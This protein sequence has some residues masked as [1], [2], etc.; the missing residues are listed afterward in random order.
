[1]KYRFG[2]QLA[3][4]ELLATMRQRKLLQGQIMDRNMAVVCFLLLVSIF[5]IFSSPTRSR[6]EVARLRS[7]IGR[8]GYHI[9][10]RVRRGMGYRKKCVPKLEQK[11]WKFRGRKICIMMKKIVCYALD[12]W[13]TT[14]I[15]LLTANTLEFLDNGPLLVGNLSTRKIKTE[16]RCS[17]L[18]TD[19]S[20][21]GFTYLYQ[22]A[23]KRC[24]ICVG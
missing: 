13:R 5:S 1:M 17:L 6:Y 11:C 12:R 9:N 22:H 10:S 15:K 21:Y 14:I 24:R 18:S 23:R 7:L 3:P 8:E 20:L 19:L 2:N 4:P 16:A